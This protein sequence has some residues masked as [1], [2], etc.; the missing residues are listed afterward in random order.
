VEG[1]VAGL[2]AAGIAYAI[3]SIPTAWLVGR[4][5]AGVDVR[6]AGEGNVGAR[7]VFHVVGRG[8]GAVVLAA[9]V[10]KGVA[11][12]LLFGDGPLWRLAVAGAFVVIGHAYPVWLG[13]VGGKGLA[14][15]GGFLIAIAPVAGVVGT[16]AAGM[17]WLVRGRFLPTAIVAVVVT[18]VAAPVTGAPWDE[19][20][21]AFGVFL[22]VAA[23]R[24]ADERRMREVESRTGWDRVR[25]GSRRP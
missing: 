23:K 22:L 18:F 14:T 19:L 2:Q 20:A 9:D 12:V 6:T 21:V 10:G 3:G 1:F 8:W 7:N 16:L 11:V 24:A 13:F 5:A 15:A 25:G 17:A 4:L